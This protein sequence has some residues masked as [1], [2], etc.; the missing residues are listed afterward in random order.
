MILSRYNG[1]MKNRYLFL[2]LIFNIQYSIFNLAFSQDYTLS[3][4]DTSEVKW[5]NGRKFYEIKAAK[6]ETLY[7]ISKQFNITQ[8]EIIQFNPDLKYG[9]KNKMVLMIPSKSMIH[10]AEKETKKI[11]EKKPE[12]KT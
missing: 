6:S 12:K 3:K 10:I 11:E 5:M 4:K 7:S 8:D 9:L 2:L 1:F